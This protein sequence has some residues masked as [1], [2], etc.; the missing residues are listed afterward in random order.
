MQ[1]YMQLSS[2]LFAVRPFHSLYR[3]GCTS[4]VLGRVVTCSLP[5]YM[6][7]MFARARSFSACKVVTAGSIYE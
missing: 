4:L 1:D 3:A 7:G 5:L 6:G 2:N